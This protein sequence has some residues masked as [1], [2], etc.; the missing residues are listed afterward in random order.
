MKIMSDTQLNVNA[1]EVHPIPPCKVGIL[2]PDNQRQH[3]TLHIQ[4]GVLPCALC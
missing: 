2:L 3:R 4:K 1:M